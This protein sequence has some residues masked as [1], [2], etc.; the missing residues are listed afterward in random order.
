MYT[1]TPILLK[2]KVDINTYKEKIGYALL[3]YDI[4]VGELCCSENDAQL[5][6]KMLNTHPLADEEI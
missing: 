6:I 4:K 5:I 1:I 2:E 3:R